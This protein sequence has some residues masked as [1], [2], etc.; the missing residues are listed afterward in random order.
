MELLRAFR[1]AMARLGVTGKLIATD[2]TEASPA[3]HK[4]DVGEVVPRVGAAGYVSALQA[5]VRKHGVGLMVPLTDLDLLALAHH[6]E[7]LAEMG[8]TVMV[9]AEADIRAC[10]DKYLAAE[11]F[12]RA[13]VGSIRTCRLREFDDQPFYPCF[14]K[15]AEGSAGIGAAVIRN[16]QQLR[17]HEAAYG[18]QLIVQELVPGQ[19]FT[20]DVYR[21]RR[22]EVRCVVPRQ[23]LEVRSGEVAKGVTVKDER[24]IADA[25]RLAGHLGSIWGAFCC[26]C[27]RPAGGAPRFFEI[28]PRFGGG[29]PLSIAAGADL[30]LYL[31][32]EVLDLPISAETGRFREDLLMLRYDES[33]FVEAKDRG[34]LPGYEQPDFR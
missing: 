11:L 18:E 17:A 31:L 26:Q 30:P 21:D 2:I 29:S 16:E 5:L 19:E 1:E 34:K 8:C 27:R 32:Q 33:V 13:G 23:R 7:A 20:I 12:R 14:A 25:T 15:P 28:N 3:F 24:L 6:R 4:A 22:G 10:R 9:G